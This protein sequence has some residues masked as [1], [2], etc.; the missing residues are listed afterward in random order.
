[1]FKPQNQQ[2]LCFSEQNIISLTDGSSEVAMSRIIPF[3]V[4]V[5]VFNVYASIPKNNTT[6]SNSLKLNF[7]FFV[8]NN[9]G[10][11]EK[12][13]SGNAVVENHE[14]VVFLYNNR[15]SNEELLNDRKGIKISIK[16]FITQSSSHFLVKYYKK[17]SNKF[18][19]ISKSLVKINSDDESGFLLLSVEMTVPL[20]LGFCV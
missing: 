17:N 13:Y 14:E 11:Y 19:L 3:I 10:Q 15:I 4:I 20:S 5:F 2:R 9:Q 16:P 1:V 12:E 18:Y 6:R 7:D 8:K